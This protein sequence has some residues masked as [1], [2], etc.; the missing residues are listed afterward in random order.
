MTITEFEDYAGARDDD[1]LS[2]T[3]EPFVEMRRDTYD[4]VLGVRG[5]HGC[6]GQ[7]APWSGVHPGVTVNHRYGLPCARQ[8]GHRGDHVAAHTN[9][10]ELARWGAL[11]V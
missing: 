10:T 11:M 9:G 3:G 6:C 5:A 1:L 4:A 8:P 2:P 7:S